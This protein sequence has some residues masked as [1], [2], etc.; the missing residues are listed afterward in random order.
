[1]PFLPPNQQHESTEGT[2][3]PQRDAWNRQCRRTC[4]RRSRCPGGSRCR[5]NSYA[6]TRPARRPSES[7][8]CR[9]C[10]C[11]ASDERNGSSY[12]SNVSAI[13]HYRR[14]YCAK[15]ISPF[16]LAAATSALCI[17]T[18]KYR[19]FLTSITSAL[20]NL[21]APRQWRAQRLFILHAHTHTPV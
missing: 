9:E 21:T 11:P 2:P 10:R 19:V 15:K 20:S 3:R 4:C 14:P 12:A 1:M 5:T 13:G 18:V 16:L 6:V 7:E 17:S 8:S